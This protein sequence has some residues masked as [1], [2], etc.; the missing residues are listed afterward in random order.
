MNSELKSIAFNDEKQNKIINYKMNENIILSRIYNM[1]RLPQF[2]KINNNVS[3][4]LRNQRK[5]RAEYG[6]SFRGKNKNQQK[7]L[8]MDLAKLIRGGNKKFKNVN[9]AYRYLTNIYNQQL[10]ILRDDI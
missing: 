10:D 1:E 5:I 7:K 9:F 6:I 2:I 3:I 8:I 4:S